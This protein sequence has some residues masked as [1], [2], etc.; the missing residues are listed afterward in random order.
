MKRPTGTIRK[1]T[2]GTNPL[3][4][5]AFTVGQEAIKGSGNTVS[6]IIEDTDNYYSFGTVRYFVYYKT[7]KG[8]EKL[9]KSF[10][11][12]PVIIEYDE[13]GNEQYV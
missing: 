13:N 6:Q 11:E 8:D 4:G 9:W 3:M 10:V 7:K 12:I 2:L 5:L 1:I